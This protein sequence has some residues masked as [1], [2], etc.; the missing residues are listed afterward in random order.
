MGAPA[1]QASCIN[2]MLSVCSIALPNT[3]FESLG[4]AYGI[5]ASVDPVVGIYTAFFPVMV[6][7][8]LGTSKHISLGQPKYMYLQLLL[9]DAFLLSNLTQ[10]AL[11]SFPFS[12][13]TQ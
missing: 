12:C 8:L 13:R 11:L 10:A 6:Y 5:L 2:K 4:M 3:S 7:V 9:S 1:K